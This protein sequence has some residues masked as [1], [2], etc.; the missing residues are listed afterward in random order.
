MKDKTLI[1]VL[2]ILIVLLGGLS[3]VL[4]L[5]NMISTAISL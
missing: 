4:G 1:A 3:L 2:V 5:G